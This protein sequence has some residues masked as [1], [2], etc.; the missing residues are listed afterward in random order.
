MIRMKL[1]NT[2]WRTLSDGCPQAQL[3][4]TQPLQT[5]QGAAQATG[6]RVN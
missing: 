6:T 3:M 4:Q 1:N 2:S 5:T